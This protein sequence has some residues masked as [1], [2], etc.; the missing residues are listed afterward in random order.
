M[1]ERIGED[2]Q[3]CVGA[4]DVQDQDVHLVLCL[5]GRFL[6]ERPMKFQIMKDI[7]VGVWRPVKGGDH[8]GDWETEVSF[9]VLLYW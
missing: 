4:D 6:S 5:V 1:W 2:D 7:M 8:S 3:L 9:T